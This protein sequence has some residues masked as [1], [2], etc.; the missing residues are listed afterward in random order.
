M[1]TG[2]GFSDIARV[3]DAQPGSIFTVLRKHGGLKPAHRKRSS[4]HLATA[5]R[6]EIRAG[7][8]AK[9]SIRSIAQKLHRPPSTISREVN[10]TQ[11][12]W[13]YLATVIDLYSRR[14]VG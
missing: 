7:L 6:E 12:G 14:V 3:L 4:T 8:S 10:R 2:A 1:E 11:E 5:E 13:L 9:M